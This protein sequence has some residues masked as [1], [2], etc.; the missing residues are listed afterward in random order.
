MHRNLI[1]W[2][3][4]GLTAIFIWQSWSAQKPKAQETIFSEFIGAVNSGTVASVTIQGNEITG[5]YRNGSSFKTYAPHDPDL[6]K[7]LREKGVQIAAK[8]EKDSGFWQSLLFNGL[9]VLLLIG[10]YIFFM[11]QMQIGGGKAMSFGKSRARVFLK[12]QGKKVTFKDVAG[13]EESKDE[14]TEVIEFLR[15]PQKF[16][17]L[18]GRIPK[19]VLLVGPPGTG[20]TLLARAIAGE[21]DVPFFSISGS[22]FVEMF[23][24][25]G[26]SRVRDLFMQ[27]KRSNPCII[28]IDELDAVGRY[29]GAGLG[30]GH[31]ERE[32]T[33]NQLLVEMDGFEV[34]EG[35]ILIAATNRPD[36]LDPAL[37]RPGRF[38][39]QVIV[40]IP[41]IKGREEILRVHSQNSPLADDVKLAILARGTPGFTGAD[42]E[43]L[44]NE[45]AL[46]AAK[47]NKKHIGMKDLEQAKDKVLM[48]TER[49]SLIISDEEKKDT[50]YHEA[51]HALV[52]KLIP[53]SDP[54][55]KVTIIPRGHALGLTQQ[56]PLDERHLYSH[57]YLLTNITT[58][59][60]GRAAEEL[61]LKRF[62]TGAG[63]DIEKATEVARKMV[64]EWGMSEAMGPLAFGQ[65]EEEIFLGREIAQHR[66]YSEQTAQE[67]DRE[68]KR[69][70]MECYTRAKQVIKKNIKTLHRVA[71]SLLERE[72]LSGEE[73]EQIIQEGSVA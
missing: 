30:G 38:D 44:V 52:A 48:G 51:G 16:T 28:F 42:L 20:K 50:A 57:E 62:T 36:I 64:C 55:H 59:M 11:R 13:I 37:L 2:L 7:M 1:F 33:L 53:G 19:G 71:T 45:A 8:P 70:V 73:I 12:D 5:Q 10:V 17:K 6:V 9:F 54:I 47:H 15:D 65:K 26:A 72:S 41:D 24:G 32:Q 27:A 66:D 60:G 4:I 46:L 14:V 68:I 40:P 39:R 21:A 22:D 43:N 23:V 67:I 63:N 18:G 31:D 49:R 3:M 29:R 61:V 25:V 56:L 58:L 35:V 34:N 69:I